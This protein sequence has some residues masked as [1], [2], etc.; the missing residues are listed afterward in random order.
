MA[1][2][3]KRAEAYTNLTLDDD[4]RSAIPGQGTALTTPQSASGRGSGSAFARGH[5]ATKRRLDYNA[6]PAEEKQA[7]LDTV[8]ASEGEADCEARQGKHLARTCGTPVEKKKGRGSQTRV[9][10]VEDDAPRVEEMKAEPVAK[11]ASTCNDE[12]D[13]APGRAEEKREEPTKKAPPR[14]SAANVSPALVAKIERN[15]SGRVL[16]ITNAMTPARTQAL[17]GA[18]QRNTSTEVTLHAPS[19]RSLRPLFLVQL[20]L[21]FNRHSTFGASRSFLAVASWQK[22]PRRWG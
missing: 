14:T 9:V 15:E 16:K 6:G 19:P 13:N 1:A 20:A 21:H 3:R 18:L 2:K 5:A 4:A 7:A 10:A 8:A 22:S 12:T 17:C 11:A